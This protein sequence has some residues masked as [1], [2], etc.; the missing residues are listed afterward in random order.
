[1]TVFTSGRQDS[2]EKF[3]IHLCKFL[4]SKDPHIEV[5]FLTPNNDMQVTKQAINLLQRPSK[6]IILV[7]AMN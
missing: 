6:F 4:A 7:P 5:H 1:M 3:A 2:L